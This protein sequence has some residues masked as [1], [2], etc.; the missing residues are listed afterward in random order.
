[1]LGGSD[2]TDAVGLDRTGEYF[3]NPLA[4][5]GEQE[6]RT[7]QWDRTMHIMIMAQVYHPEEVSGAVLITELA[8]DLA[9][10]GHQV[11]MVTCAPNYP[12]GQVYKGYRNRWYQVEWLDGVRV[13]RTWTYISHHKTFCRRILNYASYSATAFYGALLA[14]R[15]DILV[16]Y[17]PPLPLGLSACSL[18]R[19][20]HVPWVL[21]LNDIYPD[22]AV[23]AGILT[24][25]IVIRFFS[26]MERFIYRGA[27]HISLISET[28]CRNLLRKAV[29][30]GKMTMIPVW[31]DPD[32]VRPLPKSN[33]FRTHHGLDG[34][35]VVMYAGN[36]GLTSS[37]EDV[38]G[39][40]ELLRESPDIRFVLIGEGVK[41]AEL[42]E[43]ANGKGLR[44]VMFLPYQ[45]RASFSEMLASADIGLVTLNGKSSLSSLPSKVFN[46]MASARPILA[47][48]PKKS[49][50][51]QLIS[52]ARCG[53][54]VSL[55]SPGDLAQAIVDLKRDEERLTQM[56]QDGR[57]Q[58]MEKFSRDRCIEM[59][60]RMLQTL[61][62]SCEQPV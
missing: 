22:A 20:W 62:R 36:L 60:E 19:L 58:L 32:F 18:S 30:D 9:K 10:R 5:S 13:V 21:Q 41:K 34:K 2:P 45:P 11:T 16:S 56:G 47:V 54:T 59:H 46:L 4:L 25:R 12:Y 1:V 29:S 14:G 61:C 50:L 44:N 53:D 48:A 37:L 15:P 49:E 3:R 24:N 6:K 38:I 33:G 8:T 42:Q 26:A 40:A 23:A 57:S 31:A 43:I 17:C 51:A 35:F 55:Q 7:E 28:F 39:A 27:T 52:E